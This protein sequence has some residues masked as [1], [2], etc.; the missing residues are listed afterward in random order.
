MNLRVRISF[1]RDKRAQRT[2]LA[3]VVAWVVIRTLVIR[4]V[5]GGYGVN[6]LVYF[7]IDLCS[8]IPYAILSGRA[9]VNFLDKNWISFRKNSFFALFFFY[10]PDMYVLTTAEEVPTSLL[11][12]FLLSIAVFSCFALYGFR[13]NIK[14]AVR[15]Q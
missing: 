15:N 1:L 14:K 6:P 8:A 4:D 11:M 7:L 2:W 5:F 13:R 12:G 10:M 9:V 3:L